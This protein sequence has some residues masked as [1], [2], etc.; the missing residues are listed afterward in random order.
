MEFARRETLEKCQ[1]LFSVLAHKIEIAKGLNLNDA[2]IVAEDFF[3]SILNDLFDWEL[4]NLNIAD[5]NADSIDLA[6]PKKRIAVQVTSTVSAEKIHRTFNSFKKKQHDL[7]YNRL[8]F[9]YPTSKR[10]SLTADFSRSVP[11]GFDFDV[12]R[13]TFSFRE[14]FRLVSG[15]SV[16][17]QNKFADNLYAELKPLAKFLEFDPLEGLV[18][19]AKISWPEPIGEYEPQFADRESEWPKIVELICG[20]S[21]KRIHIIEGKTDHGKS[22]LLKEAKSYAKQVGIPTVLVD[23]KAVTTEEELLLEFHV[24]LGKRLPSFYKAPDK[25]NLLREDLRRSREPVFVI[26]DTYERIMKNKNVVRLVEHFLLREI[27]DA[28]AVIAIVAGQEVPDSKKPY[29]ER[30]AQSFKLGPILEVEAWERW[31]N[32]NFPEIVP[33]ADIKLLVMATD[34]VPGIMYTACYNI[35]QNMKLTE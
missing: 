10:P 2:G 29:W 35:S 19:D 11:K 20:R 24:S 22:E 4:E 31:I 21:P 6:Y 26:F 12:R 3:K 34:G 13:D 5:P 1:L 32:V 16:D 25:L 9:V 33:I 23:F 30:I 27:E 8:V 14:L 28:P 7:N 17:R 18:D 15:L